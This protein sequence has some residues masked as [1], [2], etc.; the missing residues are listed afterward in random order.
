MRV[1]GLKCGLQKL[2]R[3]Q[4]KSIDA[5]LVTADCPGTLALRK[6]NIIGTHIRGSERA[7][8]DAAHRKVQRVRPHGVMRCDVARS[9]AGRLGSR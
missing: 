6:S 2:A 5:A 9:Q 7:L 1:G 8:V 4:I 3:R